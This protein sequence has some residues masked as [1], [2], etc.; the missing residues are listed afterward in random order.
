MKIDSINPQVSIV[1]AVKDTEPYLRDCLDSILSQSYPNWELVAVNDNSRD[2]SLFILNEYALRD[3]RIKVYESEGEKLIPALQT[4]I[5]HCKG[6]LINRMDSDDKMPDYKLEILVSE[7]L[8][9]GKGHVIAGGTQ[10]F[11][12]EGKVGEGFIRYEQWLNEVAKHNLHIEEIYQECVIPSHSWIIHKE[13]FNKVGAFD[14]LVYPEDYDLCFRLYKAGLKIIGIDKV[15]HYWRD[16]SDRI[17]RTWDCYKDN[18]YFELKLRYFF[19][20]DRDNNRPLILWGAGRNGKDM[21][22]LLKEKDDG[23]HW[24]C[25]NPKKIGKDVYGIVMEDFNGIPKIVNPQIMVVV[26][27]PASKKIIRNQLLN[28]NKKPVVDFW[29]F[30]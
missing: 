22:K 13:D 2:L 1:M 6:P 4:G 5:K 3:S 16:R 29:F 20:L 26:A 8:K 27:S 18:R 21:A 10:H 25:N 17:S 19:E 9:Y 14:P 24:V 23:F 11:V 28:W 30:N 15:L 7:W 12:D